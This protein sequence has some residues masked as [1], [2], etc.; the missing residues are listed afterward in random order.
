MFASSILFLRFVRV[1]MINDTS[2]YTEIY[3][4]IIFS[5]QLYSS[6]YTR[7]V[8]SILIITANNLVNEHYI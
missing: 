2:I 4:N 5:F 8:T 6:R 3:E 7:R 1:R